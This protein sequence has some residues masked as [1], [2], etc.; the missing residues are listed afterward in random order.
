[1][2]RGEV[3][4]QGMGRTCREYLVH[5]KPARGHSGFYKFEHIVPSC[6]GFVAE[7]NHYCH[8]YGGSENHT[9]QVREWTYAGMG[10]AC[11]NRA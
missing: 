1:M 11:T 6:Q 3:V 4:N 9:M 8:P 10:I 7:A 5:Y 2:V